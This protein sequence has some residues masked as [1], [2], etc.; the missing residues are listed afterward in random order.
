MAKDFEQIGHK[1]LELL[2]FYVGKDINRI[3]KKLQ[4]D[5]SNLLGYFIG[6]L[7]DV[8]IVVLFD[9]GLEN[10]INSF[11]ECDILKIL[12]KV[13]CILGLIAIFLCVVW[14][15]KVITKYAD[16]KKI[17]SG[18][19]IYRIKAE[20]QIIIDNFD[21]IACD[22][23]LICQNYIQRYNEAKENY[24]KEFYLYEIIHHL[25]KARA[26]F[27]EIYSNQSLYIAMQKNNY[28]S[29][30]I[31]TYRVNNFIKFAKEILGFLLGK[32]QNVP[33]NTDLRRDMDNLKSKIEKWQE[34][35]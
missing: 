2:R 23:L 3:E 8:F 26:I 14:L 13:V 15:V 4:N 5:E 29:E 1:N 35:E 25:D 11:V 27:M 16:K 33:A 22:G 32:T 28:D 34:I 17:T 20:Q 7:V 18:E 30:L 31:D 6:S 24:V 10:L 12:V 9:Q 21:N 19:K